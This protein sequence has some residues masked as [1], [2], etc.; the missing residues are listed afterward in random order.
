M[1]C[2]GRKSVVPPLSSN[3]RKVVSKVRSTNFGA[4]KRGN[5]KVTAYSRQCFN[6]NTLVSNVKLCPICGHKL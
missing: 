3:R 4:V 6:C 2:C 5:V 1:S